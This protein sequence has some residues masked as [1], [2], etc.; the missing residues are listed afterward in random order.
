M[1]CGICQSYSDNYCV[2]GNINTDDGQPIHTGRKSEELKIRLDKFNI[3]LDEMDAK[4][5]SQETI[6]K[7]REYINSLNELSK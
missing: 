5:T 6:E 7:I 3:F 2:C 1:S 4:S